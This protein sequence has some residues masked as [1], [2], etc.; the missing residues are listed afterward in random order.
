MYL[1][2][3]LQKDIWKFSG[4][5]PIKFI[6]LQTPVNLTSV[7]RST[8]GS[9]TSKS[10]PFIQIAKIILLPANCKVMYGAPSDWSLVQYY[11]S[12]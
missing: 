11:D 4:S 1:Y 3:D 9:A 2:G 12:L 7:P 8:K 6:C 5:A 10:S